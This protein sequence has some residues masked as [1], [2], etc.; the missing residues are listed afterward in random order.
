MP[1]LEGSIAGQREAPTDL[2]RENAPGLESVVSRYLPMFYKRAFWYLGNAA[3][4]EG[5]VQDAL[6]SACKHWE[7]FRGHAQLSTWLTAIV[8]NTSR[9]QLRRRRA[10]LSLDQEYGEEGLALSERLSNFTPNPEEACSNSEVREQLLKLSKQLS[11]TQRKA[12][13]LRDLDGLTTKETAHR[14]GVPEGTVKAQVARARLKLSQ[15]IS[16]IPR[17]QSFQ[18]ISRDASAR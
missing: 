13:Q 1:A 14:L 4:A 3:D 16:A 10:T 15:I 9:M 6:L 2:L 11:P 12:F 5:A 7:Q 18:T 8:I 17:R